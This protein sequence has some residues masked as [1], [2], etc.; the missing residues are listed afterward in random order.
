MPNTSPRSWTLGALVGLLLSPVWVLIFLLGSQLAG[1]PFIPFDILDWAARTLPGGLITFGIDLLASGLVALGLGENL[2]ASAKLAEQ[3]AAL[4]GFV[5]VASLSVAGLF[6]LHKRAPQRPWW[7]ILGGISGLLLSLIALAVDFNASATPLFSLLWIVGLCLAFFGLAQASYA[8]LNPAPSAPAPEVTLNVLDRR[9]FLIGM[10]SATATLTLAG[11]GLSALLN[12]RGLDELPET[13][14]AP[15]STE[16][17]ASVAQALPNANDPV[18]PAEGTRPEYTPLADHYRIDINT[19]PI[20]VE[21]ADY[22]LEVLGKVQNPVAW[23]LEEIYAMPSV[24]EY[25]TMACISN[26]IGGSLISTTKWT[27]VPMQYI[28]EQVQP[29][30]DAVAL[31]IVGADGF[32]EYLSLD[33]IRQD[34]RIMLCHSFDDQRLPV[35]NGFPLRVHIPDRYGMKQPKWITR[36]EVLSQMGEGYWVRRG[37]SREAFVR[38]TSV[39]DVVGA[40]RTYVQ[41]GTAYVPIGGIAWAGARGISKVEIRIDDGEWLEA[42]LRAPLSERSWVIWRYDWAFSEGNHTV[43]V[44]CTE[45]NGAPQI[46]QEEPV[47]PDG[48]TGYHSVRATLPTPQVGA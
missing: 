23:S 46:E 14:P 8:R 1:L 21:G 32:D 43:T 31:Y 36:M 42:Q 11:A 12:Q 33:L 35:P 18:I 45:S 2:S 47:R 39:V 24:S 16:A 4:V 10:G 40:T 37:W 20:E 6:A 28:L 48:A 9:R 22:R 29:E 17:P 41:D 15:E 5:L 27:G 30:E 3:A 7:L 44:R 26:P 38:A 25:I 13:F 34:E 19:R